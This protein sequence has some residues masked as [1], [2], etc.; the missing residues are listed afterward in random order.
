[1]QIKFFHLNIEGGR[2]LD[3]VIAYVLENDFDIIHLQ[4]VAGGYFSKDQGIDN[5]IKLQERLGY[6]ASLT[7]TWHIT[8]QPDSYFG[9]ATFS[10]LH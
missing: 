6:S 2:K 7:K 5:L 4:E 10:S 8:N 9:N 3:D 1:M